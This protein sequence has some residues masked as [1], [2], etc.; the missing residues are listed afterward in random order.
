MDKETVDIKVALAD[1]G[2]EVVIKSTETSAVLAAKVEQ[3]FNDSANV[4]SLQDEKGRT[5]VFQATKIA[6]V[7]IGAAERRSVGFLA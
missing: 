3:V 1:S 2:R 5:F 7:E 6:C 4:L